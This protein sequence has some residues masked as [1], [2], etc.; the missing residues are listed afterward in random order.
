MKKVLIVCALA[1][2]F[3]VGMN[4]CCKQIWPKKIV[5][6]PELDLAIKNKI[7]EHGLVQ[8]YVLLIGDDGRIFAMGVDGETFTPCRPPERDEVQ[9]QDTKEAR[10]MKQTDVQAKE[11]VSQSELPICEGMKDIKGIFPV[12]SITLMKVKK[13]PI[14]R[15][16][17]TA[18]GMLERKCTPYPWESSNVCN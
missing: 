17:R 2:F 15:M 7:S 11:S 18:D 10:G 5:F 8:P 13:N 4:G 9:S 6:T 12:E 14:Y 1:V 16:V 3:L